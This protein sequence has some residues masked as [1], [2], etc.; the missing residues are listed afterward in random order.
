[1][2]TRRHRHAKPMAEVGGKPILWQIRNIHIIK[3]YP[4]NFYALHANS[5]LKSLRR[6]YAG[7]AFVREWGGRFVVPIPEV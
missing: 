7:V 1:M 3:K 2:L 6:D 4:P 5:A